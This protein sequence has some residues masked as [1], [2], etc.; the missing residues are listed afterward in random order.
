M[1]PDEKRG[2]LWIFHRKGVWCYDI[3]T[4]ASKKIRDQIADS[5]V[6]GY[7]RDMIYIPELDRVMFENREKATGDFHSFWNPETLIWERAELAVIR[8]GKPE[9]PT[10]STGHGFM[11]DPESRLLFVNGGRRGMYAA[12]LEPAALQFSPAGS[13]AG[14][15][16]GKNDS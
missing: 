5:D 8:N 1:I 7:L 2:C 11:R 9:Q 13:T 10:F 15:G 12:R 4:G 16:A 6:K 14:R 3:K